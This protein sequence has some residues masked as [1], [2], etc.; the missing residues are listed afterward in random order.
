M[1]GLVCIRSGSIGQSRAEDEVTTKD[2]GTRARDTETRNFKL[3]ILYNNGAV[4][5]GGA[6]AAGD[7]ADRTRRAQRQFA[8]VDGHTH[9]V[10]LGGIHV[11]HARKHLR[12]AASF[13]QTDTRSARDR[14]DIGRIPD[15]TRESV[16]VRGRSV[17]TNL[18][19]SQT[20]GG[21]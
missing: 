6:L 11:V 9:G 18:K 14:G 8:T 5:V 13:D 15:V 7:G 3:A 20:D 2:L 17:R 1:G 21:P 10:G 16:V 19:G 4:G 12:A